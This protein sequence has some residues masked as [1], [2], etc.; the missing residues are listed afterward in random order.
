MVTPR[1]SR[2]VQLQPTQSKEHSMRTPLSLIGLTAV[3][4]ACNGEPDTDPRDDT[5]TTDSSRT[6]TLNGTV[7]ADASVVTEVRAYRVAQDGSESEVDR[8]DVNADGSFSVEIDTVTND[9]DRSD[10]N[11]FALLK[12]FDVGG[13]LIGAVLVEETGAEDEELLTTPMDA[14]STV[15][16]MAWLQIVTDKGS[17]EAANYADIRSRVDAEVAASVYTVTENWER[18]SDELD[19]LSAA[20]EAAL[21]TELAAMSERGEDMS[22]GDAYAMEKQ[23]SLDLSATLYAI[24]KSEGSD[25]EVEAAEGDFLAELNAVLERETEMDSE[26]RSEVYSQSALALVTVLDAQGASME[27]WDASVLL[28]GETQAMLSAQAMSERAMSEDW[29]NPALV[30]ELETSLETLV[31]SS[32]RAEDNG[33]VDGMANAWSEFE[34]ELLG[35]GSTEAGLTGLLLELDVLGMVAYEQASEDSDLLAKELNL[36]AMAAAES[37]SESGDAQAMAD[38]MLLAWSDYERGVDQVSVELVAELGSELELKDSKG[39]FVTLFTQ[40]EGSFTVLN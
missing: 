13:K 11:D 27:T 7:Q 15:E 30:T 8:A 20:L 21:A 37:Y 4:V 1:R 12:G 32:D 22:W 14:E 17:Y 31:V 18:G 3:L 19:S 10:T 29:S 24:A 25:E 28:F 6:S 34:A 35:D 33:N 36:A 2:T 16:A 39:F 5:P 23:A 26:D 38:A 40:S 9:G